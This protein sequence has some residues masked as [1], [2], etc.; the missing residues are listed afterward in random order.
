MSEI[1]VLNKLRSDQNGPYRLLSIFKGVETT[2][3]EKIFQFKKCAH[4]FLPLSDHT[5]AIQQVVSVGET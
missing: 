5:N 4:L 3:G 1:S 2:K